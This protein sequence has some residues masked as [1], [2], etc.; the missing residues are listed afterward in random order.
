[1]QTFNENDSDYVSLKNSLKN[2]E[3]KI[4]RSMAYR[5]QLPK[6]G[7]IWYIIKY[8]VNGSLVYSGAFQIKKEYENK[9]GPEKTHELHPVFL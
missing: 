9:L 3:L 8:K 6:P 1:M 5:K 2:K 7:H 4:T